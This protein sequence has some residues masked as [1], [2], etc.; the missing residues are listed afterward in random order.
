[1]ETTSL[2]PSITDFI[3]STA[4]VLDVVREGT[5]TTRPEICRRTGLARNLVADRVEQLLSVGLIA[6]GEL[7]RS[8]G[9]RAPRSLRFR[10][11]AGRILVAELGATLV[12]VGITDLSGTL[13]ASTERAI[14][15]TAGPEV[16]LNYVSELMN[17]LLGE[18]RGADTWGIGIG[19][20]GPVEWGSGRP[21]APPIMPGWDGFDVRRFFN[22]RY[23]RPVW[24]DNDVNVMAT[25]E[26]RAG[27]ARGHESAIYIKVGTGI[28][29]GLVSRGKLHRGA[30]GAAGD[31]GHMAVAGSSSQ[32]LCRCGNSGCLEA[33]AGGSA[34]AREAVAAADNPRSTYLRQLRRD[35]KE[36]TSASVIEA[37]RHADPVAME[38]LTA[39]A[40]LVGDAL[41]GMVNLLNPSII[42]LGGSVGRSLDL[43]L[44]TVRR[45]VLNRSLPLAT[46]SLQIVTS[47]LGDRAGLI[48]AAYTVL[49]ELFSPA[50]LATW[51][52]MGQPGELPQMTA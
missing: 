35:G 22:E 39:S 24:V 50:I 12:N 49:D 25:G 4:T 28:G 34:L 37:A 11:D 1:M 6:E 20:P 7:G 19:L 18:N 33:L 51:I 38:L 13:V 8:T 2:Q 31:I 23:H 17:A 43:Y 15:V 10:A 16:T 9:G 40:A 29:A 52:D 45:A 48:G 44:A 47:P 30:Q 21:V 32:V 36:L 5:A 46:R 14:D 41:A 27:V 26:V 3:R 42:V